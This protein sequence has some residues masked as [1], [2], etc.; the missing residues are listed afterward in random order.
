MGALQ[1][2]NQGGMSAS[3]Q[4]CAL[5]CGS[6]SASCASFV[7]SNNL[8]S[9][10]A[11]ASSTPAAEIP[12]GATINTDTGTVTGVTVNSS[13][14][15]VQ[16]VAVRVF[17]AAS[18]TIPAVRI[19]GTKP[20]AFVASGPI[21]VMGRIDATS[22]ANAPG[23]GA[24]AA[25]SAC[26][27]TSVSQTVCAG[28]ACGP[29]AGGGG[30][31]TPGG[32]GAG[33]G[34]VGGAGGSTVT[35][36][37]PLVGGCSGGRVTTSVIPTNGGG[38]IQLVSTTEVDVDGVIDIS[39][40]GGIAGGGGAAGGTLVIE[41]PLISIGASGGVIATG[42][43]GADGCGDDGANGSAGGAGPT[44]TDPTQ[45]AGHGGTQTSPPTAA[46]NGALGDNAN[47]TY[48]S[49]GGSVGRAR[50]ATKDGTFQQDPAAKMD[51]AITK[52]TLVPQ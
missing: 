22:E 20:I 34:T 13:I 33:F 12:S 6:N 43:G 41:T 29:G 3:T 24:G 45:N 35:S 8:E 38:A 23:P 2:C 36:F 40:Q 5:G 18:W 31:A 46:G 51:V 10:L 25:D 21:K 49:G 11:A 19:I 32:S 50:F 44:C 48:G 7:P 37:E 47:V 27:G 16:N 14:V 17:A 9:A 28:S 39:G 42:G 4:P 1:T 30:G 26:A 15:M 52:E